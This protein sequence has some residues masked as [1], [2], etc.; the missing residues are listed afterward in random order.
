MGR[1]W[2]CTKSSVTEKSFSC[3]N[4][5]GRIDYKK[6]DNIYKEKTRKAINWVREV[7][8]D[9]R[10]WSVNPPSRVELYPNMCIDSGK[11]NVEKRKIADRIGEITDIWQV[12]VKHRNKAL[13][14]GIKSWKDPECTSTALSFRGKRSSIVDKIM[15]INRQ[16]KGCYVAWKNPKQVIQ[17]A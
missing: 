16:K 6:V 9:G 2:R 3:L 15:A 11:W 12:G 8:R 1:R 7:K 14:K 13:E 17:L 5:L 10:N 4:K